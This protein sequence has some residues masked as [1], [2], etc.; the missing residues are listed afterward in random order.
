[1]FEK[2]FQDLAADT[3]KSYH[4][5]RSL[6]STDIDVTTF[7]ETSDYS[8]AHTGR[9]VQ[10][11]LSSSLSMAN[12]ILCM[13]QQTSAGSFFNKGSYIANVDE[14]KCESPTDGG[15]GGGGGGQDS[16]PKRRITTW[17]V[18]AT[19]PNATTPE[20]LFEISAW[21][22]IEAGGGEKMDLEFKMEVREAKRSKA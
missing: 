19:G 18:V 5:L 9:N 3:K 7:T 4:G 6:A 1:M 15:G 10:D 8:V 14:V 17:T 13:L 12:M 22:E 20:G 21:L 11:G 16:A 2:L